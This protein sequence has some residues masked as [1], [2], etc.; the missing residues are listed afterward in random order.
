MTAARQTVVGLTLAALIATAWLATHVWGVFFHPWT[1]LGIATA[2]PLIAV[3]TWLGAG[4]FIV[5]HD[6]MHGTVSPNR[7][8]NTFIGW[9]SAGLFVFNY[10]PKLLTKHHQHH[11]HVHT[12]QDPDYHPGSFFRWYFGF[13]KQYLLWPQLV[14][15]AIAY[16]LLKLAVP[17]ANIALYWVLPSLLSTLQLFYFGTYLPHRG[18]HEPG[19]RHFSRS[20]PRQHV[21]AFLSCYFFGYHYEHHASP[22][23]P[24]WGLPRE[25]ERR[26]EKVV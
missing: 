2:I 17:E 24:W 19:N 26:V 11:R 4:M 5:A 16:N 23:T 25:K 7:R 15:A 12:A 14:L 20:Q 22:G 3:Q 1:P 18:E 10:Y 8:L 9:L 13:L 21:W 6:A